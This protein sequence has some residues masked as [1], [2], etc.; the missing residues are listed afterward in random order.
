LYNSLTPAGKQTA[1][2]YMRCVIRGKLARG[3]PVLFHKTHWECIKLILKHRSSA[4]ISSENPYVFGVPSTNN[5]CQFL[6]ACALMRDFSNKCGAENPQSLRGTKLRKHIA[7]QSVILNLNETDVT[8]LASF[9]G[10]AEKIHKDHYRMP[11]PAREITKISAL[12]ELAQGDSVSDKDNEVPQVGSTNATDPETPEINTDNTIL[13]T[14]TL[15]PCEKENDENFSNAHKIGRTETRS[16]IQLRNCKLNNNSLLVENDEL[17]DDPV[18]LE[19]P[20]QWS[21]SSYHPTSDEETSVNGTPEKNRK[22]KKSTWNTPER[23]AA[24][25]YLNRFIEKKEL[26]PLS[27]CNK[28][29]KTYI[30]NRTGKQLKAW[31]NNQIQKASSSNR[32]PQ[33]R[34][35]KFCRCKN[36]S[37][38]SDR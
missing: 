30:P 36:C 29:S 28:I 38:I 5:K 1:D 13:G 3:V 24:R 26:P 4:G 14:S 15:T 19:E 6:D 8:D 7:T 2:Q 20:Y 9:M 22:N 11:L 10:H 34:E 33:K 31:I 37:K 25:K 23:Q 35:G 32:T 12:L 17:V 27:L 21:P 18:P 16:P